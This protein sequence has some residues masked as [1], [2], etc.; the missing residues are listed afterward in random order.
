MSYF[1]NE[2]NEVKLSEFLVRENTKIWEE[3][4]YNLSGLYC[5]ITDWENGAF[6]D[7]HHEDEDGESE[8]E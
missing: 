6:K 8:E 1:L 3:K 2:E 5:F 4:E 7:E